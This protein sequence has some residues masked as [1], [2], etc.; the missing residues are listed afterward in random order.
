[1]SWWFQGFVLVLLYLSQIP[2]VVALT[3]PCRD[4]PAPASCFSRVRKALGVAFG[5]FWSEG[6]CFRCP[7]RAESPWKAI[8]GRKLLLLVM[9]LHGENQFIFLLINLLS[10][11][12]VLERHRTAGIPLALLLPVSWILPSTHLPST[13]AAVM[14]FIGI[15]ICW[16]N[17]LRRTGHFCAP[18]LLDHSRV[19]LLTLQTGKP[20]HRGDCGDGRA[21]GSTSSCETRVLQRCPRAAIS[22][23]HP[24]PS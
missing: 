17:D 23:Y 7:S 12:F 3:G 24:Q 2:C 10:E 9:E 20:R 14:I 6:V 4:S 16:D 19:I 21:P 1:M 22:A 18:A 5:W 8:P 15:K 11:E 13:V